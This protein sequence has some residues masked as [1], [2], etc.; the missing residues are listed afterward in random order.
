MLTS[1]AL[2]FSL[3]N[4]FP[5]DVTLSSPRGDT[6]TG[7]AGSLTGYVSETRGG[8]AVP[9]I[10]T[11]LVFTEDT[12]TPATARVYRALIPAARVDDLMALRRAAFWV[13]V[14]LPG[15]LTLWEDFPCDRHRTAS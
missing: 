8:A 13:K 6:V 4:P 7:L 10:D 1:S 9:S 15:G 12:T 3:G 11:A 2:A 5:V 14:N